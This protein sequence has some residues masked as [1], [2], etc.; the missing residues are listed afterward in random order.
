MA[1]WAHILKQANEKCS[2]HYLKLGKN[3]AISPLIKN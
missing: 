3:L 2:S 1:D